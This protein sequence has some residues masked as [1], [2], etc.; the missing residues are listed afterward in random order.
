MSPAYDEMNIIRNIFLDL[1]FFLQVLFY[2]PLAMLLLKP[3]W[4]IDKKTGLGYFKYLDKMIKNI[5]GK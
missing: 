3:L 2:W 5:A 4:W 1:F